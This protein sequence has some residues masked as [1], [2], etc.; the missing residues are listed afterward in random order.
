MRTRQKK[1]LAFIL[2]LTML[3]SALI[4]P[5]SAAGSSTRSVK[6][7]GSSSSSSGSSISDISAILNAKSYADY[8]VEHADKELGQERLS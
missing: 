2:A 6:A 3:L 7:A 8:R 5:V 4:L 1:L